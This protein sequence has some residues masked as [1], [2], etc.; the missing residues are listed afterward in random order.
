MKTVTYEKMSINENCYRTVDDVIADFVRRSESGELI[1]RDALLSRY[2]TWADELREFFTSHD[3][4]ERFAESLQASR[5]ELLRMAPLGT[6]IRYFGDYELLEEIG[7]GGMGVVYRAKQVSLQREVALKMILDRSRNVDR[8]RAEAEAAASLVHPN[9][10]RIHEFGE[11]DG[12]PYYSMPLF[13]G[14]DL[15]AKL[16]D[17]FA[18][19][20][21]AKVVI[22]LSRAVQY[23]HNHGVLHRDLKPGN[24]LL[25][26]IGEPHVVDFG[27]AK[28]IGQESHITGSGSVLGTP[29][30]M[31][32]EQAAGNVSEIT[33]ATDVYGLGAI[34]YALLTGHAPF[35]GR[36]SL[37][38]LRK[39]EQDIPRSVRASNVL[40][41]HDLQT[42]CQKCLEKD[43]VNRYL[44]AQ[45]LADDLQR[46]LRAEPVHAR[47]VSC[48][49]RTWRWCQRNPVVSILSA[50]VI[51]L[52][53]ISAIAGTWMA[54]REIAARHT[55][56]ESRENEM[57]ARQ[58]AEEN[59]IDAFV[60]NGR[61]AEADERFT[62]AGMWYSAAA[63]LSPVNSRRRT[64]SLIRTEGHGVRSLALVRAALVPDRQIRSMQFHPSGRYVLCSDRAGYVASWDLATRDGPSR[65]TEIN[66]AVCAEW[67]P[68]G[69]L[70][71]LGNESGKFGLFRTSDG[72]SVYQSDLTGAVGAITFDLRGDRLA[73][74]T[75]DTVRVWGIRNDT[76]I[77]SPPSEFQ[78]V[79]PVVY[80]AFNKIGTRLV[81]QGENSIAV[82]AVSNDQGVREPV[83]EAMVS[84]PRPGSTMDKPEP[85]VFLD[86][87]RLLVVDQSDGFVVDAN[88]GKRLE[89]VGVSN[90]Q[91]ISVNNARTRMAVG[92]MRLARLHTFNPLRRSFALHHGEPVVAIQFHPNN[93]QIA[94]GSWD[95][96]VRLWSARSGEAIG[97]ARHQTHA[98]AIS[99]SP[100][101]EYVATA[102]RDGLIRLWRN[103][104]QISSMYAYR[105]GERT[106]HFGRSRLTPK[107]DGWYSTGSTN[108]QAEL[109]SFSVQRLKTGR[110]LGPQIAIDSPLRD[111]DFSTDESLLATLTAPAPGSQET[112]G[113]LAR[114]Q[115]WDWP[116]GTLQGQWSDLPAFPVAVRFQPTTADFSGNQGVNH[117][118]KRPALLAVACRNQQLILVDVATC[119]PH[120]RLSLRQ[121]DRSPGNNGDIRLQFS[122]DGKKLA[123]WGPD[124]TISLWDFARP[125]IGSNTIS[126]TSPVVDVDISIDGKYLATATASGNVQVFDAHSAKP[127][128]SIIYHREY[129]YRVHFSPDTK[130]LATSCADNYARVINWA[131]G[132]QD[133][134]PMLHDG[135][136]FDAVF[137][138]DGR[139]LLTIHS[140]GSLVMWDTIDG[141]H[142]QKKN[143][144]TSPADEL[145][146]RRRS[147]IL[148]GDADR[149]ALVAGWIASNR[150]YNLSELWR[151]MSD[152]DTRQLRMLAELNACAQL[153][154]ANVVPLSTTQWMRLWNEYSG[155]YFMNLDFGEGEISVPK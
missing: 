47:P 93:N 127:A 137:T 114:L 118:L 102:Q 112:N 31:A 35:E 95:G 147:E 124:G 33:T 96:R 74:A 91:V 43:P 80:L 71:A 120:Q 23:A 133:C 20:D 69:G 51:A 42:I 89:R 86:D 130:R 99:F 1:D 100:D 106:S 44:S 101:G 146:R 84:R 48:P 57:R 16:V 140:G 3:E 131:D 59:L 64:A 15:R 66:N 60:D 151:D 111:A 58:A 128:C 52:L 11:H 129:V 2:P 77:A 103:Q 108:E 56:E 90:Y 24:V 45:A 149:I 55:A 14:G 40:V 117:G 72:K 10:V 9:I 28:L 81:A 110:R 132:S 6:K 152:I 5:S 122:K 79:R 53:L 83:I 34:L 104:Y 154:G 30:Y 119:Q 88:S 107:T 70:L 65:I 139:W 27:L 4:M 105:V 85:P 116:S 61:S 46:F 13:E 67:S 21:A 82:F 115:L 136:V 68:R 143:W 134:Q 125:E 121:A 123:A 138:S 144:P 18:P 37:S 76:G 135:D 25:D 50:I 39:V 126:L 38:V 63:D 87:D 41:T 155:R 109:R 29:S 145:R 19:R 98:I 142:V 62:D 73:V 17:R 97:D 113:E 32:P 12:W 150:V 26:S 94:T 148:L 153:R 22:K 75:G 54:N 141:R 8:F 78:T 92:G 7:H 36:S 49:E